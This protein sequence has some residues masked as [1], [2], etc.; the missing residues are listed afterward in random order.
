MP[1]K[2]NE[3]M[4]AQPDQMYAVVVKR[5]GN[6]RFLVRGNNG[7]EMQCVMR[8][9]VRNA[10]KRAVVLVDSW[11]LVTSRPWASMPWDQVDLAYVYTSAEVPTLKV[12]AA[13]E[14]VN[15]TPAS[16]E[17]VEFE[18]EVNLENI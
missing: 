18:G 16:Y 7:K 4:L 17:E 10:G 9:G 3:M 12:L 14:V 1:Q 2:S 15:L 13:E 11:V 5:Y 8:P 6:G